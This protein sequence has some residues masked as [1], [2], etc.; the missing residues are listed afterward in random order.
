MADDLVGAFGPDEW[1]GG[2]VPAVDV[3]PDGGLEVLDGV[4]RCRGGSLG[5]W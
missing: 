4:E 5:G 2:F 3:G 1:V